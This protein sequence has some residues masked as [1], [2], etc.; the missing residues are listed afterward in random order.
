[1]QGRRLDFGS[2]AQQLRGSASGVGFVG[3]VGGGIRWELLGLGI[4]CLMAR[5]REHWSVEE[6][7]SCVYIGMG[8]I[9][10]FDW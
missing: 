5:L 7:V 2:L 9:F 8:W 6:R 10:V 4:S 3:G 1:L